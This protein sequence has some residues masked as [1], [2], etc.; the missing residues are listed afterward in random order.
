MS[1]RAIVLVVAL[2]VVAGFVALNLDEV[3]RPTTLNLALTEVQAPVGLVLLGM[4]GM[5]VVLFLLLMVYAQTTHLMEVRRISRDA[6]EQRQLADKA[7]ASRFTELKDYLRNEL[8][9]L[10]ERQQ[11]QAT[12]L[13]QQIERA[14]AEMAHLLEQ[15]GNSLSAS[16]GE[17]EDR[18]ERQDRLSRDAGT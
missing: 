5:L 2:L 7:E 3:F 18:M 8:S 9:R 11:A 15:T 10:E 17:M 13:G 4:L 6:A 1:M 16:L 12:A 14:Q